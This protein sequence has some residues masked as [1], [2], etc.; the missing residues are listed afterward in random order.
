MHLITN[1]RSSSRNHDLNTHTF[2]CFVARVLSV[3]RFTTD[4]PQLC[5]VEFGNH[6]TKV[7]AQTVVA[8]NNKGSTCTYK[9]HGAIRQTPL[10]FMTVLTQTNGN[11][12]VL[13]DDHGN[14]NNG[15]VFYHYNVA[16]PTT[17]CYTMMVYC[18][19]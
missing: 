16:V 19:I 6:H 3:R 8:Q 18:K 1:A 10:H 14:G 11:T 17:S 4:F 9:L 12:S 13:V 15:P 5:L 7:P 2:L